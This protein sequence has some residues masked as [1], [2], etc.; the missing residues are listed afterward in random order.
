MT[1]YPSIDKP[2]LKYY[3]REQIEAK[4]PKCKI[5]DYIWN[6]NKDYQERVALNYFDHK[7][8]Y[9]RLFDEIEKTAKA[10]QQIGVKLGDIVTVIAVT[11]PE[12]IYMFYALNRIGAI[13]NM[14]DP[15]TSAEGIS[16]YINE[17]HSDIVVTIDAVY[18]KV[19][20]AVRTTSAKQVIVISPSDSLAFP[21][22][23]LYK[24]FKAPRIKY[25]SRCERWKDFIRNGRLQTVKDSP[26]QK[27]ECCVIVHTGGTTGTPKGVMLSNDNLNCS[28]F[29]CFNSS[30]DFKRTH[31]WANIMPPF[32]A[33]GV[34]NGLHL[35]LVVGMEVILIPSF[36]PNK[37]DKLLL[38]YHPSHMAG[39]PSHYENI[40]N[41]PKMKNEDISYLISPIVGGDN[42]R[43]DLEERV[44]RFIED[45]RGKNKLI[46][47][48]GMTEVSAAVSVCTS[49]ESNKIG[50]VGIPFAHTVI[51]IFDTETGEELSYNQQGEVCM[52]GPN[53]MIGYYDNQEETEKILRKHGDG[54]IWVHSG[55]LGYMDEDGCLFVEGRLKRMIV[56]YDGFK[57]YPNQ[58]ETVLL[59]NPY[60]HSCCAVGKDDSMHSQG[61]LPVVFIVIK[62][63]SGLTQNDIRT[64]LR[65]LCIKELPEYAQPMEILFINKLPLTPIGKIDYR[66]LENEYNV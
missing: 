16:A 34:G 63:N 8:T 62:D 3:T 26:Y 11:L 50:G 5:Y 55:D 60:V 57:V 47:G 27:D 54:R 17:V 56:R 25:E 58:I 18:D 9:S 53:T 15:R 36:D 59:K 32:I 28:A 23:Q 37:F 19:M 1:G 13:S 20:E 46:K 21:K 44:D 6:A 10:F 61:R 22:K 42:M 65:E 33:Y 39:V 29:Q 48:Y 64:Q 49:N 30:L 52:T 7:I 66:A 12:T 24:A 40:M 41:S 38:K 35:P 43:T 14:I 31:R 2:W 4:L 45:H 51:S